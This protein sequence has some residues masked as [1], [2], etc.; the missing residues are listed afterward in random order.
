MCR[1]VLRPYSHT[2]GFGGRRNLGKSTDMER[3]N[4][5]AERQNQRNALKRIRLLLT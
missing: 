3:S 1:V 2:H 4:R 5:E